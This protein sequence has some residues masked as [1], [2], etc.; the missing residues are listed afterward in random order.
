M[1]SMPEC[2]CTPQML[3]HCINI[4]QVGRGWGVCSLHLGPMAAQEVGTLKC[5][6]V[7]HMLLLEV[8]RQVGNEQVHKLIWDE[9]FCSDVLA[10]G[11]IAAL[12]WGTL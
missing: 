6:C 4:T 5:C 10:M 2:C 1:R 3:A 8:V 7:P 11:Y 9:L 12:R